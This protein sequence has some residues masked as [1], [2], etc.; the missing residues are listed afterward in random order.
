MSGVL[1]IHNISLLSIMTFHWIS[2]FMWRVYRKG[3]AT[4]DMLWECCKEES[5]KDNGR[6]QELN[7]LGGIEC[8]R[9]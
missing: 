2:G 7:F 4:V 5:A 9:C 1:P 8:M 6:R 3:H